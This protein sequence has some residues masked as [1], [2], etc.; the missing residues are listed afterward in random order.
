MAYTVTGTAGND[1]LNQSSDAG[2]GTIVGL[3]G[4][5][6]ILAG[7]G[8]IAVAG[9]SGN[10]TIRV[11][12]GNTGT[13]TGGTENDSIYTVVTAPAGSMVLFAGDGADTVYMVYA[14]AGQT[15]LGGNNAADGAD[16]L[17][18]GIGSDLM[19]GNGGNDAINSH[20][21]HDTLVGG[22][23]DDQLLTSGDAFDNLVFANE[24]NDTVVVDSG[25]DTVFGGL[26]NDSLWGHHE[27]QDHIRYFGNE[28]GDSINLRNSSGALTIL[29]GNDSADGGDSVM[30][31]T[32]AD[33]IFGNGGDDTLI[34]DVGDDTVVCGFGS[35]SILDEGGGNLVF[36]N[37]GNDTC[38]VLPLF[39]S[40]TV[41]GG[42]GNDSMHM[43][44]AAAGGA[45]S[46][47][48]NEGNDTL[49]GGGNIDT[50]AGGSGNDV[51]SYLNAH[52]DGNNAAGGGPVERII[53]LNWA[54]DRLQ[55]LNAVAFAADTGTGTGATLNAAAAGAIAAAFALNGSQNVNVAAQ[56]TFNGRTFVA[57]NQDTTYAAFADAGDLL[58]DITGVTGAIAATRFI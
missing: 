4:D 18:G 21:G 36:G 17:V 16:S 11:Q 30:S 5:D 46:L 38:I 54:E 15:I 24:G 50:L 48:G 14:D 58:I 10:D 42:L 40:G 52:D 9:D 27:P 51:F 26:G 41:F 44:G 3:A 22:F 20:Y 12:A 43:I 19:F 33:F 23:G 25:N 7:S 35:N 2:P 39:G 37:E 53:D 57:I 56:F 47:Q 29:G 6:C 45:D 8:L 31:G 28:G 13:V 1:T 49:Y 32:G 55:A 34:P